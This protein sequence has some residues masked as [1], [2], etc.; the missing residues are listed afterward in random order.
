M[1]D[2]TMIPQ[3]LPSGSL[4]VGLLVG[5]GKVRQRSKGQ[6]QCQVSSAGPGEGDHG[7]KEYQGGIT[8]KWKLPDSLIHLVH[9]SVWL[10]RIAIY[11]LF[12]VYHKAKHVYFFNVFV[13]HLML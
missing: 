10:Q 6:L 4:R 9:Y 13:F 11:Y 7:S 1:Q 12:L 5:V 2:T 3:S 8:K